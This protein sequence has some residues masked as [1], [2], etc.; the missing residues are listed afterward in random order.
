MTASIISKL[1]LPFLIIIAI[2]LKHAVAALMPI[3]Q[4]SLS[5][6]Q[7]AIKQTAMDDKASSHRLCVFHEL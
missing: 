3:T 6:E 5:L 7:T 1:K 4:Y 2:F